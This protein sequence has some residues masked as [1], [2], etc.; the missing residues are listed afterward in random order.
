LVRDVFEIQFNGTSE[1]PTAATSAPS[2]QSDA[3]FGQHVSIRS[4][5]P[6][7]ATTCSITARMRFHAPYPLFV[8]EF[9]LRKTR[10]PAYSRIPA[11]STPQAE[12]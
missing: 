3:P 5:K 2:R 4:T 8:R 1:T 6:F 11:N 10:P 7:L 9:A 12:D